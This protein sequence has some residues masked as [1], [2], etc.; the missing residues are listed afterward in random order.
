MR[1]LCLYPRRI[2]R[3]TRSPRE[4][5]IS[6]PQ[7]F[8][9]RHIERWNREVCAAAQQSSEEATRVKLC[10]HILPSLVHHV[11]SCITT[12]LKVLRRV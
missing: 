8:H 11:C 4:A 6:A 9:W 10:A 3:H 5:H 7:E 12:L 2:P 1:G